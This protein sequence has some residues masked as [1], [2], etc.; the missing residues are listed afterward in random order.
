MPAR[1][2]TAIAVF[3]L[4]LVVARA[5]EPKKELALPT[6]TAPKGWTELEPT[7]TDKQ[8][9]LTA[10][11]LRAGD[12]DRAP[13]VS[14][15]VLRG[16][17]GGLVNNVNRW[18]NQVQLKPLDDKDALTSL[19]PIKI[20]GQ[21][22]HLLDASVPN[23]TKVE[24]KNPVERVVVAIVSHGGQTVYVRMAGAAAAVGEQKKAFDAFV[25]SLRLPK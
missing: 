23:G 13:T 19:A 4:A 11:R 22:G 5:E 2:P 7:V 12:G 25:T 15:S 16:D 24:G 20:D 8:L 9:G 10:K 21:D 3:L 14:V 6:F 18:R 1:F 17:G